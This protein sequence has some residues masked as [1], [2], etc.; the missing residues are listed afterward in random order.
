LASQDAL[1]DFR[2]NIVSDWQ[3]WGIRWES[4]ATG[5]IVN[6]LFEEGSY[7]ASKFGNVSNGVR[8]ISDQP[9]YAS[10]LE[11]RGSAKP[12]YKATSTS[13]IAAAPVTTQSVAAMEPGV[14]ANAG[15]FPRDAGDHWYINLKDGWSLG[16]SSP[17]RYK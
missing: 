6:S 8:I 5:N 7:A 14:R 12:D 15:A 3:Q 2:N 16:E 17:L 13:P 11:F 10:G 9:V 1:V 4:S